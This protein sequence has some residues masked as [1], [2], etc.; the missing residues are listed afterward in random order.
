MREEGSIAEHDDVLPTLLIHTRPELLWIGHCAGRRE[1]LHEDPGRVSQRKLL[2]R[3]DDPL[4]QNE[5]RKIHIRS[6]I[7]WTNSAGLSAMPMPASLN[8]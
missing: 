6:R 7:S 5:L 2:E 3:Y 1:P 4:G 8:A